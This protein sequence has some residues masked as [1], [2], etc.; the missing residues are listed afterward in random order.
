MLLL[1]KV[2]IILKKLNYKKDTF[3]ACNFSYF[4][5]IFILLIIIIF[6]NFN[7]ID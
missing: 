2:D 4:K 5:I 6:I 1:T 7:N 3:I